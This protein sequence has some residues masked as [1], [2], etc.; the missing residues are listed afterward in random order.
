MDVNEMN[1]VKKSRWPTTAFVKAKAKSIENIGSDMFSTVVNNNIE[2]TV[3]RTTR[4]TK[5]GH[6]V[7]Y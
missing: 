4:P 3:Q 6:L 1:D 2:K 7:S 5:C